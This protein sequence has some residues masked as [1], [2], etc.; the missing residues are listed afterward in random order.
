MTLP[1]R[2][3]VNPPPSNVP[4]LPRDGA[5]PQDPDVPGYT[6]AFPADLAEQL[7]VTTKDQYTDDV[8]IDR[9]TDGTGRARS[10]YTSPKH[11]ITGELRAITEAEWNTLDAFYRANR[12]QP[13][14]IPWGPCD[15][16]VPLSVLFAAP[17]A[18]EFHGAGLSTA[19]LTLVEFP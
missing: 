8:K 19:T 18:R 7:S 12:I 11:S 3:L 9:A 14:T 2:S 5:T 15:A 10:F 16:P 13:F 1:A 4:L 17:P 6:V